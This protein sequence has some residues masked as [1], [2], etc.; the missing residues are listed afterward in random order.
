MRNVFHPPRGQDM[1]APRI[2]RFSATYTK[3]SFGK[4]LRRYFL[5]GLV[6]TAPIGVTVAV[7]RWLFITI[8]SILGVPLRQATGY[9]LP[10]LGLVMLLVILTIVGWVV[11]RTAGRLILT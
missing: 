2:S 10:G 1:S 7:L 3:P 6:V 5:V 11:H 8:D 4:R 9:T